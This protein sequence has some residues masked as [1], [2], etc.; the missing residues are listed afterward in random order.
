MIQNLGEMK[1]SA[2]HGDEPSLTPEGIEGYLPQIRNWDL[3]E[4]E[5]VE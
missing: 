3:V 5:G 4:E 2:C 1:C